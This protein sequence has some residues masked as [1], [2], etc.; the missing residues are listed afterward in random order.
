VFAFGLII[1][2]NPDQIP[3]PVDIPIM[4]LSKPHRIPSSTKHC[5]AEMISR[6]VPVNHAVMEHVAG[7][8]AFV[9]MA[10]ITVDLDAFQTAELQQNVENLQRLQGK[11]VHSIPAAA[12]TDS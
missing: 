9:A 1:F 11:H 8:L 2:S 4:V 6:V 10:Q 3:L 12:S 5:Y 7:H